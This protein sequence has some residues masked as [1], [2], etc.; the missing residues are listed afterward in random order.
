VVAVTGTP[1]KTFLEVETSLNGAFLRGFAAREFLV[2]VGEVGG[3]L[4]SVAA[5]AVAVPA[6]E[7]PADG[8]VAVFAPAPAGRI[9]KRT[10][11]ATALSLSEPGMPSRAGET[12]EELRTSIDAIVDY[13]DSER[14][15][16]KRYQPRDGL[17]FCNVYAHDFCHLAGTYL[18]RVWW[19]G[20]AI[21][22]LAR[23]EVV[24]PKLGSTIREMRANDL[25]D[26]LKDF[27][28]RF[29]W[30]QT[31]T[32]TRLQTE[33]NAGAVGLLV[34][35]RVEDTKPGH[36]TIVVPETGG[37][38]ARRDAAGEVTAPLQSQAGA[39]NFQ[40]KASANWWK[41][42]KFADVAFWIHG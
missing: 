42:P 27:G 16:H 23:G 31:G 4:E 29:G 39:S 20:P 1:V 32:L 17:T 2:P 3:G 25:F 37:F 33:A 10:A 28:L 24:E 11:N 30:R 36:I 15:S 18:P 34:A 26:W 21:E 5:V 12:P 22:R 9:T 13:L 19:T 7:P 14:A 38:K 8:I 35:C 40:R 41:D 6:D